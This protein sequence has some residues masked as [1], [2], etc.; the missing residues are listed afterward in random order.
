M[1]IR[2]MWLLRFG[3]SAKITSQESNSDYVEE[4]KEVEEQF[5]EIIKKQLKLPVKQYWL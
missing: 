4:K 3:K 2:I 1:Y 5:R